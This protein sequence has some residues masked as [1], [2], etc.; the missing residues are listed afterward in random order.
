MKD[1]TK[2]KEKWDKLRLRHPSVG[3]YIDFNIFANYNENKNKE[4]IELIRKVDEAVLWSS[5]FNNEAHRDDRTLA[6]KSA[7]T[8]IE[9]ILKLLDY[10]R[11]QS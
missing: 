7:S 2:Q 4:L 5:I 3:E 8:N 10:D 1:I 11:N 6:L 9:K